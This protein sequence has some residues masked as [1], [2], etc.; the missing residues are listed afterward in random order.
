MPN[1]PHRRQFK[2]RKVENGQRKQ[3]RH[4]RTVEGM[5]AKGRKILQLTKF[6]DFERQNRT[7]KS[8]R[9]NRFI[10]TINYKQFITLQYNERCG[11]NTQGNYITIHIYI[12]LVA[13]WQGRSSGKGK[14]ERSI[15]EWAGRRLSISFFRPSFWPRESSVDERAHPSIP[16]AVGRTEEKV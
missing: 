2:H 8:G 6:S 10:Y 16:A 12:L 3:I 4:Q 9:E 13:E 7:T 1:I 5:E 14:G 15:D 11:R